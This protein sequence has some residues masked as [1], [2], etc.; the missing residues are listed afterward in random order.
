MARLN[1]TTRGLTK[2]KNISGHA[3]YVMDDKTKLATM[4]LT[5]LFA[6]DKFYGDNTTQL[7]DLAAHLCQQGEGVYMAKLAVWARTKGNLRTVS[8]ALAAVVAHECSGEP[9][10]RPMV[11][12]IASQRGDDGTEMLAVDASGQASVVTV[13]RVKVEVRPMLLV[14]AS[15]KTE[16]G[17]K[18]GAI[19][20]QNAETIRLTA[21]GGRPVSVVKLK[22]GDKVLV[23]VDEAGRHFGMRI[24]EDIKE[25]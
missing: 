8:H 13:G 19:F 6:E 22:P 10:V 20:L 23:R 14:E 3:A 4:A 7:L 21:P 18:T 15:V 12:A 9:F 17:E 11:R 5:T 1:Q 25:G 16:D 2:T 24:K